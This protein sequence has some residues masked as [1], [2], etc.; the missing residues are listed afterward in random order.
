MKRVTKESHDNLGMHLCRTV[1][2]IGGEYGWFSTADHACCV[3]GVTQ[4]DQAIIFSLMTH[5]ANHLAI[6]V[7]VLEL[8][9]EMHAFNYDVTTNFT[10]RCCTTSVEFNDSWA[11]ILRG[12]GGRDPQIFGKEGRGIARESWGS[13]TG[14]EILLYLNMYREYVQ[15]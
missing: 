7:F 4:L 10:L 2:K 5:K 13:W 14:R 12:L 1:C 15:K 6:S 9:I 11:S 3:T 8:S